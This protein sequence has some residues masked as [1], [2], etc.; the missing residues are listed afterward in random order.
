MVN[1]MLSGD[2]VFLFLNI[3]I[4][5]IGLA[6]GDCKQQFTGTGKQQVSWE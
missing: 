3:R 1:K 2:M 5:S 4:R 6:T